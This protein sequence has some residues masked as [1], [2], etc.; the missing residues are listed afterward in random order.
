MHEFINDIS[1]SYA[2]AS[3][4]YRTSETYPFFETIVHFI[5]RH[6][7]QDFYTDIKDTTTGHRNSQFFRG[8][9]PDRTRHHN[10]R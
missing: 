8:L 9:W 2:P 4:P 7:A 3:K 10:T 6:V 5:S 1:S